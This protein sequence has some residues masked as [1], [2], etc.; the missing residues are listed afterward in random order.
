MTKIIGHR[1]AAGLELENTRASLL[2]AMNYG[3]DMIEFDARL[4]AD[5]KLVVIHDPVTSNVSATKVVVHEKTLDELKSFAL[6]NGEELLS[7]DEALDII[8]D[9]PVII[10]IKE[11]GSADELLLAMER[12]PEA[13][14]SIASRKLEELRKIRRIMPELPVYALTYFSPIEVL[15]FARSI[16]ATG[17]G[18]NKW[19]MNPIA[20][21]M[22]RRYNLE[23][24]VYTVNNRFIARFMK[25]F[26][27]KIHICTNRPERF[28]KK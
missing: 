24:Y 20:Y 27:P 28:F 25:M 8:G 23:I 4:T 15:H 2:A 9:L 10:D 19:L 6:H 13:D 3:V 1:G 21:L 7:L 12:H 18:L 11:N 5:D 17:V 16:H 22:A 14:I 26:Y